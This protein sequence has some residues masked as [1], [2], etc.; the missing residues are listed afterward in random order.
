MAEKYVAMCAVAMQRKRQERVFTR[1]RDYFDVSHTL[2]KEGLSNKRDFLAAVLIKAE[3]RGTEILSMAELASEASVSA[4]ERDWKSFLGDVVSNLADCRQ[5]L[6][7]LERNMHGS[8]PDFSA[9]LES[10]RERAME[11]K[12]NCYGRL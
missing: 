3:R 8:F 5:T 9:S 4:L 10:S 1:P 7:E 2:G 6:K 11:L 12:K